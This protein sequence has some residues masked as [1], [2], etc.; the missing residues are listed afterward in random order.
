MCRYLING[1]FEVHYSVKS[2][3]M[4]RENGSQL[5]GKAVATDGC[6]WRWPGNSFTVSSNLYDDIDVGRFVVFLDLCV[7]EFR[8]H[9]IDKIVYDLVFPRSDYLRKRV[10]DL[11]VYP[12]IFKVVV[13][14]WCAGRICADEDCNYVSLTYHGLI[15]GTAWAQP[16]IKRKNVWTYESESHILGETDR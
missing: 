1:L 11:F 12:D 5:A 10:E 13:G 4:S 7:L 16:K 3:Q 14:I 8:C 2:E 9:R 15:T 6:L